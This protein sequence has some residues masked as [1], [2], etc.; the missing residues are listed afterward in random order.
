MVFV[1]TQLVVKKETQTQT[2]STSSCNM[3]R[4]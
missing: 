2:D 4:K 3:P 1:T